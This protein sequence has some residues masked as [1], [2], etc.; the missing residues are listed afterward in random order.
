VRCRAADLVDRAGRALEDRTE[1]RRMVVVALRERLA[2]LSP[3]ATLERGYAVARTP[4]RRIVRD[5]SA[6]DAGS[7]VEVIVA[8]GVL[9]TRVESSHAA[10]GEELLA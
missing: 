6:V 2:T 8:A 1:R 10:G 5:A 9:R 4:D 7:E 3:A